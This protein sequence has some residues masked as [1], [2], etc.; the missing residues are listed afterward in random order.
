MS[1]TEKF[2]YALSDSFTGDNP[3]EYT[4]GFANSKEVIAFTTKN[5]RGQWLT[6]TKLTTAI[7]ITRKEAERLA[8]R[9]SPENYQGLD[10]NYAW[11][12]AARVYRSQDWINRTGGLVWPEYTALK[13]SAN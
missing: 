7:A 2:F 4:A 6:D 13:Y 3:L 5:E 1:H 12:K 11:A 9:V 10:K 8:D